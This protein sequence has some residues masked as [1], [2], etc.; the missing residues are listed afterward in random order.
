MPPHHPFPIQNLPY[1]IFSPKPTAQN[2]ADND[3]RV[4]VRIGDKVVD[5]KVLA[6]VGAFASPDFDALAAFGSSSLNAFMGMGPKVWA[7]AR[8]LL[9]GLL[10]PMSDSPRSLEGCFVLEKCLWNIDDVV[11]HLPATI[12]DYTDFYSSR[13]HATTVG[14]M[15]RGA[16]NALQPNWLTLPVGYHGRS[17]SIV[18]SG[19]PV[20]R[21]WGQRQADKGD[22]AK[23]SI[24]ATSAAL[25]YELEVG[26]F[27]GAPSKLGEPIGMSDAKQH[28]FGCVLLNDWSARDIQR[29]EY[30]PLGPFGSKNFATSISCWVVSMAALEPF[31]VPTSSGRQDPEPHPY[32]RDPN[33]GSYDVQLEVSLQPKNTDTPVTVTRTSLRNVYWSMEQQLVHHTVTGCNVNPGDLMG[34]GTISGAGEGQGGCLLELTRN[35][36]RPL[37]DSGTLAGHTWLEDGDRVVLTGIC[38]NEKEGYSV[39]FGTCEGE[40]FPA[41]DLAL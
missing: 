21:P 14:T 23:G 3:P 15:F 25:D 41:V 12:G 35:G 20:R 11:M 26:F 27:V 36:Q 6:Q 24:F 38:R 33:Y 4:G 30:V 29:W 16:D 2:V 37:A 31:R 10:S 9:Q 18:A 22:P 28:I 13:E 17:S 5:L 7:A 8:V 34:S 39:G 32:L 1:G 40:I 19:T